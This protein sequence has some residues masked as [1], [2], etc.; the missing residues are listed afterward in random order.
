MPADTHSP[1]RTG[2]EFFQSVEEWMDT[3][4][5]RTLLRDEFPEDAD[6]WLDPVSRRRFLTL[7]GASAALAGA[8]GCNPSL[9]PMSQ[10]KV[11]PYVRQ[12]EQLLP[13]VPLFFASAI[14]QAGGVGLGV[15]VKSTEGRPIKIEGNPNHPSSLGS[16][17]VAAQGT[18]L[19][20]YDP[21]RSKSAGF[22]NAAVGYEK[23]LNTIKA[24][25]AKQRDKAGAGVRVVSE[26]TTSP[27]L[28]AIADE[29]LKRHPQA[30]WVQ[31]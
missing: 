17:N 16:T 8:V 2:A 14:P 12:P 25:L 30:K 31:Y 9:K 13:G 1:D 3:D 22:G 26:P 19:G 24:E 10:R 4:Q 20:M 6:Q 15:L 27:T 23:A 11:V 18:L 7:M 21:E 28:I 29:F 5:F